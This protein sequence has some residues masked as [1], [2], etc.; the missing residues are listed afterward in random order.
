MLLQF[1]FRRPHILK[2][3]SLANAKASVREKCMYEAYP[4]RNKI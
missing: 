3:E 4:P 1:Y 2:Q